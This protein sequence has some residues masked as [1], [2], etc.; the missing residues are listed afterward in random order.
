MRLRICRRS[1]CSPTLDCD[2]SLSADQ[3][4]IPRDGRLYC[5]ASWMAK[6]TA[7]RI[8]HGTIAIYDIVVD[9]DDGP[10]KVAVLYVRLAV[11]AFLIVLCTI[12]FYSFF[13]IVYVL[14]SVVI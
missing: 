3:M 7:E 4:W 1:A 2:I 10:G 11:Q 13:F 14:H 12:S 9:R 6:F 5:G 8:F